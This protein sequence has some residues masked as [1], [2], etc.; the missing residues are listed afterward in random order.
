MSLKPLAG[1]G[2]DLE[3]FKSSH[4]NPDGAACVEVACTP[5]TLHVRDS[6]LPQGPQ[7]AFRAQQWA[8]FVSY[9]ADH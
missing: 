1:D 3:W 6:K 7:L 4:S 8:A 5:G 2:T 9:A